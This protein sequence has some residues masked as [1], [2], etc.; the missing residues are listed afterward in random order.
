MEINLSKCAGFC[1]GVKRAYKIVQDL[2]LGRVRKPV[3]ILGSLVH[4]GEVNKKIEERGIRKIEKEQLFNSKPGEVGTIIITAHGTGPDIFEAAEKKNFAVLD[5]TCPKVIKVQRLAKAYAERGYKIIIIGDK[6]HKEVKGID[7]WGGGKSFII[8]GEK[9]LK[10]LRFNTEDKIAV[11]AQTTQ[12]KDF[13]EKIGEC[14]KKKY[15]SAKIINTTCSTTRER[16]K[17]AKRMAKNN[18]IMIIIGSENSANS[19]RLFEIS[20]ELNPLS[21]FI[22]KSE[23]INPAWFKNKNEIGIIAGAS[24]PDWVIDGV[25]RVIQEIK[26]R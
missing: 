14:I 24:T 13:F 4:N 8:C 23:Y 9:D 20:K 6:E 21:Y 3:F 22:E 2:D 16:Q 25:I 7:G 10:E 5:T 18:D 17:E 15:P 19:R 26:A 1:D 11:L 12:N